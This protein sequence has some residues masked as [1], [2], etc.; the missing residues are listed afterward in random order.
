MK[1]VISPEG[2][3]GELHRLAGKSAFIALFMGI[4][5]PKSRFHKLVDSSIGTCALLF[6]KPLTILC[7]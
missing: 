5:I 3:L 4:G 6:S 1:G 7:R 2:G